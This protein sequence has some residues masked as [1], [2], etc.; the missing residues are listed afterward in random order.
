MNVNYFNISAGNES[1]K[2]SIRRFISKRARVIAFA[3]IP[4]LIFGGSARALE[5]TNG[6]LTFDQC[7]AVVES[8]CKANN[9]AESAVLLP[10]FRKFSGYW[11]NGSL[12]KAA[13]EAG[14]RETEKARTPLEAVLWSALMLACGAGIALHT[15]GAL[16]K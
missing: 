4:T 16:K 7:M 3:M 5:A 11:I 13:F 15:E 1:N 2:V 14:K 8:T 12:C 10:I 9:A 6:V